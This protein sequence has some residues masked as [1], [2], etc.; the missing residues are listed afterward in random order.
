MPTQNSY[1][2]KKNKKIDPHV[3]LPPYNIEAEKSLLGSLLLDRDAIIKVSDIVRGD[4]FYQEG[5]GKIYTA[6]Q[7]LFER[8]SPI[9]LVTLSDELEK[10]EELEIIGGSSYLATLANAVPTAAHVVEYANIVSEK[11]TLRGLISASSQ[12]T[13]LGF[14]EDQPVVDILDKAERALFSVSQK[15]LKQKFVPIRSVLTE[16]FDRIDELHKEK[17]KV[18]GIPTGFKVM[19]NLLSGLQESDLVVVAARPSMGK[20]TLVL[21]MALYAAIKESLP[22]GF[23]SL[24]MS[25]EQLVDRLLSMEANI[26]SWKLRTGNL[27]EE[28]FERLG[29]AMGALS[30][31]PFYIDDTPSLNVME[32]RTKARRLQT[33]KGLSML[34]VDYLQLIEGGSRSDGNRVQEMSQISRALKG[35]AR[36]L[37]IPVLA[38]SQLSRAVESRPDK[39]PQLADL[40]ESGSIEQDAD[41]VMFIYREDYYKPDTD[42]KN[43]AQIMVKKHRNGPTG[44]V[45]LYFE[46]NKLSFRNLEKNVEE[47]SE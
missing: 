15:Y 43:I 8:R 14:A 6:V 9:D 3:K 28:D 47:I 44:N 24:E 29:P 2:N 41:V 31:I 19:D 46:A 7:R 30:E 23:F 38:V 20:T 1:S 34:V 22:V 33:E 26:D 37:K 13:E 10:N 18:R 17:G 35:I 42:K 39:I 36:E 32:I 16:A 5:H 40:R 27:S 45:E 11:S 12:I 25:K 21:N 4:D